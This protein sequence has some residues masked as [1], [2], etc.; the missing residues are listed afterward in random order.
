[1]PVETTAAVPGLRVPGRLVSVR[2]GEMLV[3]ACWFLYI[4]LSILRL[5]L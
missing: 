2:R 4:S 3:V 5:F 1:M